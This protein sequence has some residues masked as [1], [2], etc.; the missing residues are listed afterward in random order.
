MNRRI[1]AGSS[2]VDAEPAAGVGGPLSASGPP[3]PA[4][5]SPLDGART[6]SQL[7]RGIV[8]AGLP[9]ALP[10]SLLVAL[11]A[12]AGTLI[13]VVV[14]RAVDRVLAPVLGGA[15]WQSVTGVLAVLLLVLA[16]VYGV[17]IVG[18][19]FGT[20]LGWYAMQRVQYRLGL[21]LTGRLLRGGEHTRL[22]GEILSR[23]TS[24]VSR[25]ARVLF[26]L[27]YPPG[28]ILAL[29][30]TTV[31]LWRLDV[32]LALVVFVGAPLVLALL[33]RM[34][35]ALERR[36]QQE[37]DALGHVAATASDLLQGLGTVQGLRAQ[38]V[39]ARRYAQDSHR[40]LRVTLAARAT[41]SVFDGVV[42]GVS[43]L[44][45]A[46][47]VGAAAWLTLT[48][49]ITVGAL[50]TVAGLSVN[51]IGPLG[52]VTDA[53]VSFWATGRGAAGRLLDLAR[54]TEAP[55]VVRPAAGAVSVAEHDAVRRVLAAVRDPRGAHGMLAVRTSDAGSVQLRAVLGE[56]SSRTTLVAPRAP[57]IMAGTVL[58]NV[59]LA[60]SDERAVDRAR[61]ALRAASLEPDELARGYG[62][63]TG[64]GGSA[65]SGGQR[66][67]VA[68][69]RALAHEPRVLVLEEPTTSVDAVTEHRI[70]TGVVAHRGGRTTI[71]IT[72]SPVF[73]AVARESWE[74]MP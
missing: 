26:V 23:V 15:A 74:H 10:G 31:I 53:L 3:P 37:L 9:L 39:A 20:R 40:T 63:D 12:F 8:R 34:G 47:L 28:E 42:Q 56:L 46:L 66:Q 16:V 65:L 14:G 2:A 4:T 11:G 54:E 5:G 33:H 68:L 52:T 41:E 18:E 45:V 13:P 30:S 19:R 44:F 58:E 7:L 62:T 35:A 69:A 70:A 55:A 1:R 6:P 32:R 25:A 49:G 50:T 71:V 73:H 57:E 24:D 64:E 43:A 60:D 21:D 67:R 22:P 48:G 29:A 59:A 17:Q 36:T 38:R 51:V 27:I 72:T 61:A